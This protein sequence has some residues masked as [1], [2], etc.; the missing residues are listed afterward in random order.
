MGIKRIIPCL[1]IVLMLSVGAV[2]AEEY[3]TFGDIA[4]TLLAGTDIL[5]RF[6]HFICIMVGIGLCVM[7]VS[8]YKLHQQNPKFIP[9][10]RPVLYFVLGLVLISLPFWGNFIKTH[11]A[12]DIRK[13]E[14]KRSPAHDVDV[15][16][17][18]GNDYGH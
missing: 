17:D 5:T 18:W 6:F 14:K 3:P 7:S 12:V 2:F 10:D 9:L 16:L 11:S 1:S 4:K 13:Q 15:P 8:L